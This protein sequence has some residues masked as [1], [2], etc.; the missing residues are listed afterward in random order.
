MLVLDVTFFG[1]F[2][3]RNETTATINKELGSPIYTKDPEN[4]NSKITYLNFPVM[5][6]EAGDEFK[7]KKK[8]MCYPEFIST[9]V[10][11]A[12]AVGCPIIFQE[13]NQ[14]HNMIIMMGKKKSVTFYSN[15][16][17]VSLARKELAN[18]FGDKNIKT[19]ER[20]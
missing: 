7:E 14:G 3:F 20:K 10:L 15:K 4:P 2:M 5:I 12:K 11:Y 9:I 13:D 6:L 1:E 18:K 17:M 19:I 16:R 8:N